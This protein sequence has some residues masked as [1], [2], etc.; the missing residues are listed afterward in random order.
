MRWISC[1][2]VVAVVSCGSVWS[3]DGSVPA[4]DQYD[5][6]L[7]RIG[8]VRQQKTAALDAEEAACFNKFAVTDCQSKVAARRRQ[9]L[10]ELKRQ[11]SVV[12]DAQR[13]QKAADQLLRSADKAAESARKAAELRDGER[14]EP[15]A[16]RQKAQ[17]E[18]VL[19]HRQQA[20]PTEPRA[21]MPKLA[22][23]LDA[24]TQARNRAAYQE[25][26]QAAEKRRK[27][28]QQRLIDHG[29]GAPPLP[30]PP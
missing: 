19:S 27:D 6:E 21:S 11:E 7:Q 26:Q 24:E 9:L 17:D 28:R 30:M 16:D 12:K 1:A 20:R 25:K 3:Q 15:Q 23:G 4:I 14:T 22:S 10:T 13:Q 8:S 18:K 2:W 29:K 5:Q